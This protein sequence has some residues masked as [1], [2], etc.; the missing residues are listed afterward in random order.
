MVTQRKSGILVFV[1]TLA[2]T[3]VMASTT[4]SATP[5][6]IAPQPKTE[7]TAPLNTPETKEAKVPPASDQKA[8]DKQEKSDKKKG[9]LTGML[10]TFFAVI[11]GHQGA[12]R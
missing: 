11:T 3:L 12:T 9:Q 2:T 10:L 4:L 7:V 8:S 5:E 1:V 6:P